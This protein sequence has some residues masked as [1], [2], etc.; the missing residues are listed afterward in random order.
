MLALI[1]DRN[2]KRQAEAMR[3]GAEEVLR[4]GSVEKIAATVERLIG[5]RITTVF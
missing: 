1:K 2:L 4:V 3:L 5:P